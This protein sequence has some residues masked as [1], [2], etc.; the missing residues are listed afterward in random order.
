[1]NICLLILS[2]SLIV[3]IQSKIYKIWGLKGIEYSRTFSKAHV[4]EGEYVEM[5]EIISNRKLL[6]VLWL[7]LESEIDQNLEFQSQ[8][9]LNIKH[10][11]FHKSFFSLM[12]YTKITRRH[13]V[14]CTK[15]GYYRLNS[16]VLSCNDAF[17]T[18]QTNIEFSLSSSVTVYPKI[19]DFNQLNLPHQS[20]QG[21]ITVRRWIIDDPFMI[22][23]VRN[24][25]YG[26][27]MNRISWNST[28]R[29]GNM[30]VYNTDYTSN[31]KTMII[32]NIQAN[33]DSWDKTTDKSIME[34]AISYCASFACLSLNQSIET[35]FASNCAV[36]VSDE[37]Y[38]FVPP[39]CSSNHL[40]LIL[41]TMARM[42]LIVSVPLTTLLE[43]ILQS[44]IENTDFYII[45]AFINEHIESCIQELELRGNQVKTV[46]PR[47]LTYSSI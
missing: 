15:R 11:Q 8:A 28:A 5:I 31:I 44:N 41:D 2:A 18:I 37:E 43:D 33:E 4:F 36:Y 30:M 23:G 39:L 3:L 26:D 35:G 47:S 19:L 17:N 1:M 46:S 13:L 40:N 16:A 27:P 42:Q 34:S 10:Q 22:S 24:Y 29:M 21:D 12:P 38:A 25:H 6:P 20:W 7:Q 9:N 45:T 32:L 14:K